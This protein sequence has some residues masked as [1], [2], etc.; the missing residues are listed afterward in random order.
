MKNLKNEYV[1]C[2]KSLPL[3]L[4]ER[5]TTNICVVKIIPPISLDYQIMRVVF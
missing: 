3:I 5:I 4:T 2:L 1:Q